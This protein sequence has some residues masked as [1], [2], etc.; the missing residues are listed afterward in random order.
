MANIIE[1][2]QSMYVAILTSKDSLERSYS[3]GKDADATV[4][5]CFMRALQNV[6]KQ[7]WDKHTAAITVYKIFP[8]VFAFD[9]DDIEV[10]PNNS[11]SF[12]AGAECMKQGVAL[13]SFLSPQEPGQPLGFKYNF[14]R[15]DQRRVYDHHAN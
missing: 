5:E 4:L 10:L 14:M 6:D 15:V 7:Q 2:G 13:V 12:P 11:I 9:A 1:K 8:Y 3:I